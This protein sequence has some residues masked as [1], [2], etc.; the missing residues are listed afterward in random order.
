MISV[1]WHLTSVV[2]ILESVCAIPGMK[3]SHELLRGLMEIASDFIVVYLVACVAIV[4]AFKAVAIK[5]PEDVG[6]L[7]I[8]PG[9]KLL[10]AVALVGIPMVTNIGG[11]LVQSI[12]YYACKT[13]YPMGIDMVVSDDNLDKYL[14]DDIPLKSSVDI[15]T[16]CV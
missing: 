14:G 8:G 5:G 6:A 1:M 2:S 10:I 15:D 12:F 3:K 7:E 16:L 4:E 9:P 11:F 13:Y